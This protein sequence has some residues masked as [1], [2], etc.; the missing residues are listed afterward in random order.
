M[1]YVRSCFLPWGMVCTVFALALAQDGAWDCSDRDDVLR[2]ARAD[3]SGTSDCALDC[4]ARTY[5]AVLEL[6]RKLTIRFT[7]AR[8]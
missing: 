1:A 3:V 4:T 2:E 5:R 6:Q 7:D 8:A